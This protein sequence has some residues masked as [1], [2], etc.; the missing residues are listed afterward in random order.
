[1]NLYYTI[2]NHITSANIFFYIDFFLSEGKPLEMDNSWKGQMW[3]HK[4]ELDFLDRKRML[5]MLFYLSSSNLIYKFSK[6][7]SQIRHPS[8]F[9]YML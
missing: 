5:K 7:F 8:E 6:I 4:S 3:K 2:N 9:N 1:M